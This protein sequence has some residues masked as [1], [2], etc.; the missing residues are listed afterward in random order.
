[1]DTATLNGSGAGSGPP[2]GD[3]DRLLHPGMGIQGSGGTVTE[4]GVRNASMVE[5]EGSSGLELKKQNLSES[6]TETLEGNQSNTISS[7]LK[8]GEW[9]NAV[10][11]KKF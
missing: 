9:V 3:R 2:T 1:M 8:T 10:Q 7:D 11:G 4:E 5:E 6:L